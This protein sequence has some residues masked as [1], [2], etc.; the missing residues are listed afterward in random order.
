MSKQP[1]PFQACVSMC[2]HLK[3]GSA[4]IVTSLGIVAEL[5][6]PRKLGPDDRCD[7]CCFLQVPCLD[8]RG[9]E[10]ALSNQPFR[11]TCS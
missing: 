8:T 5:G 11:V 10:A 7:L 3:V 4:Y 2:D 1:L 9:A 6:A